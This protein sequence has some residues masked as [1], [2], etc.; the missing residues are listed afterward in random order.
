MSDNANNTFSSIK[1]NQIKT[2]RESIEPNE[3]KK[4]ISKEHLELTNN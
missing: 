4:N 2:L 3:V 1:L